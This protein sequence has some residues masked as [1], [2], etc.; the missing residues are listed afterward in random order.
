VLRQ[1]T[2]SS[3]TLAAIALGVASLILA[4]GYIEDTLLQLREATIKSRLGH[5][6]VYKAGLYASGGQRPFEY[7]I[8]DTSVVEKIVGA[9]PGV[10]SQARRLSFSGLISNGRGDLPIWGEGIEPEPESHIGSALTMLHG[11]RLANSDKMAIVLGEGLAKVLKVKVGDSVDLILSTSG[12][13]MN[14]LDFTIVGV[15]RSMSKEYDARGVQIPLPAAAELVDTA[16]VGALVVLLENTEQTEGALATLTARLPTSNYEVKTWRELADFFT[17]T[18]AFYKRQFAV[19][20]FVILVMVLLSVANTVNM[21]LHERM[22]E[23][24]IIRAL[25]RRG[26][27]VFRLVMVESL[28]LGVIGAALGVI[29][30]VTLALLISAA[31]IPMPPGPNSE[32][33]LIATIR[34]VPSVLSAAF[35]LGVVGT[36]LA[37]LLPARRVARAPLVEALR[38]AI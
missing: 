9:L 5:L 17:S 8:E 3:L 4:G 28:V 18:E 16:G 35:A 12:G 24:G 34:L 10:V 32:A 19:L 7:L 23:F 36:V 30:G 22:G 14:T 2:R 11:R 13:A 20:N 6:Q 37:S 15:F 31:G 1:K 38:Q 29:I 27:D 21:T 33:G 26:I 25:G